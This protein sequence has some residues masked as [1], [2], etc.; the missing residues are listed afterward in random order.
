MIKTNWSGKIGVTFCH[1]KE[2]KSSMHPRCTPEV[3]LSI[4]QSLLGVL[5]AYVVVW[6]FLDAADSYFSNSKFHK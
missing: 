4:H 3:F 5:F 2:H 1:P 6:P